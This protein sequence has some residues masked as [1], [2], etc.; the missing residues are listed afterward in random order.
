M[1]LQFDRDVQNIMTFK[2]GLGGH[3][4]VVYWE[5]RDA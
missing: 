1:Q 2:R 5:I 4:D 3:S